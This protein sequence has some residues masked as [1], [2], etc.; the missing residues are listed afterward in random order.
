M[1][2]IASKKPR[3]KKLPARSKV[4][5]LDTWDLSSLYAD[6]SAWEADFAK[7]EK[8]IKGYAPFRG[9]LSDSATQLARCLAFDLK[10]E[11]QAEKLGTY[12]FLRT[13]EDTAASVYQ[14]ILGRYQ[15]AA[16]EASQAASF[17]RPE[18][19]AIP[20]RILQK[21][22]KAK[23]LRPYRVLLQRLVRYKPHTLSSAEE[24]LLAMQS[25]MSGTADKTFRQ[26]T[27]ADFKF[28][29]IKNEMGEMIEL[30]HS[31][32]SAL[33]HA[34]RRAVRRAAFHQYYQVYEAHENALA[35]TLSGSVQRDVYYAKA[36]GHASAI[37]SALFADDVP[38]SVYDNLIAAVRSSAPAIYRYLDLRRRKMRLKAIHH[39]D[40]YAPILSG[41]DQQRTWKQAVELVIRSL[42]PLGD[43]YCKVLREGLTTARWCDRYPNRGKQSGAFSCGT[44]D[45]APFIMMNYQ[46]KVLDHVFTLAHEAGHSMHSHYSAKSQPFQYYDY[47]IFV[48]EVAST[49]NEQLL[50]RHLMQHAQSDQQRAYLINRDIDAIR[51]TIIR[52]TMFAEFEKIIHALAEAGEPLTVDCFKSE[53]AK[54][55]EVYFG[56][57]FALDEQLTLECL[58][59]PHF[60]RAFYVY[61]YATGLSA[62]IALSERVLGGGGQELADYLSFLQGGCSKYPLE[63]L[64]GAGVDMTSP[65]PVQTALQRFAE[66][67]D[68]LEELL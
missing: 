24:R 46:P 7:W 13:T 35:A 5:E 57:D 54:L 6:D 66:L 20:S 27:D 49:F 61:K 26:L 48:A 14:R 39:Y 17:I 23:P 29:L 19:L 53:Y 52:Q 34:P 15:H 43:S 21:M 38:L 11:R 36:R 8:R 45:G 58:R 47:V 62:A 25:Q 44:F 68:E 4:K 31:S 55:L 18:I 42:E 60:Y 33:L 64:K 10:F 30:S 1:A 59:I 3:Q 12:A 56:P 41:L 28:G 32:F 65:E 2:A 63:L 50:S 67:V 37:Q 9:T 51:G 22:L 40:T 16:S